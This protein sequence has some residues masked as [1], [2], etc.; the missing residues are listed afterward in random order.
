MSD[1]ARLSKLPSW[2]DR[3]PPGT[4]FLGSEDFP[5]GLVKAVELHDPAAM[6]LGK[7]D[8]PIRKADKIRS[9]SVGQ[10]RLLPLMKQSLQD[11]R[12]LNLSGGAD[13]LV[14]YRCGE[15]FLEWLMS[16]AAPGSWFANGVHL[17]NV[18]YDNVGHQMSPAMVNEAIRF[19]AETLQDH[20]TTGA[21]RSSKI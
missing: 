7:L 10:A 4:Q 2:V 5:A 8:G 13:K 18:I 16:A 12:I 14:P 11:K 15:A 17:E 20:L 9:A 3:S 1:R 21:A 19:I 6:L